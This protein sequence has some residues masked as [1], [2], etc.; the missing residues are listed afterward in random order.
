MNIVDLLS[1]FLLGAFIHTLLSRAL[2]YIGSDSLSDSGANNDYVYTN[3]D[4]PILSAT[5]LYSPLNA[6]FSDV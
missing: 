6:L 5:E 2:N 1:I 4:R 3:Q